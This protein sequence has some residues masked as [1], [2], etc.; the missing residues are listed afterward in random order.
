MNKERVVALA[1]KLEIPSFLAMML[2]LRGVTT[3]EEAEAFLGGEAAPFDPFT[4]PDMDRAVERI[5]KAVDHFERIAVYGDYDADG[6]TATAMLY[7]Y[8]DSCGADVVYYIPQREGEGYG[9]NKVAVKKLSEMGVHLLIT[10]DNGIVSL[11]E[12]AYATELGIDVVVTDHHRPQE[13]LPGACAVVDAYRKDCT[14]AYR[15]F[16]G[17][18]IAY[19]L[20]RA[21]EG[22]EG[23]DLVEENYA[24]LAAI[25]TIGD[26]VPLTGE[27]RRLVREGVRSLSQTD[28]AGLYALIQ[29]ASMSGKAFT[30]SSVAF[31]LVPR[32]NAAGRIGSPEDALRLLLC[33]DEEDALA[34]AEE[35]CRSNEIRKEIENE[36]VEAALKKMEADPSLYYDRVLVVSGE[37]WHHG[38]M[39]I[40]ASRLVERFGKPCIVLAVDGTTAKGSGRSVKGFSLFDALNA[41]AEVLDRYGGHTMAAGLTLSA[42]KI[43]LFREKINAYAAAAG[44]P[45]VELRLDCKLKSSALTPQLPGLLKSLEPYGTDNP[46][47]LFGLYGMT[48]Q[49]VSPIGGGRHLRILLRKEGSTLRCVRF[50]MTPE[51]FPFRPGD[52]VDAAVQL[53]SQFYRGEETLTIMIRDLRRSGFDEEVAI[54]GWR[55]YEAFQRGD[56]L[57]AEQKQLLTPNREEF[58]ALFRCLRAANGFNGDALSLLAKSGLSELGRLLIALDVLAQAEIICLETDTVL[59]K[60]TL[61]ATSGKA[62]LM[63]TSTMQRLRG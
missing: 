61:R 41:C 50:G 5:R 58:S 51:Q 13:A 42:D 8:L 53:D 31:T 48:L 59:Y 16:S 49:E 28:K 45:P 43:H 25:G 57:S 34:L 9:M 44:V 17:A 23:E 21:L 3:V 24:D 55:A 12:T 37:G 38:V 60:I 22:A 35:V 63:A 47:P 10:V 4:L 26:V 1:Q 36:I 19:Q 33:S 62:D 46:Q 39:G 54:A 6:V 18:G 14:A 7:L 29:K 15:D 2:V 20:I 11:E 56:V 32:I 52:Q 40:A 27:N 30:A